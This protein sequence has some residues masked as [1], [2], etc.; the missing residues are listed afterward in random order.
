MKYLK[1]FENNAEVVEDF[2]KN[3]PDNREKAEI[4][5]VVMGVWFPNNEWHTFTVEELEDGKLGGVDDSSAYF[6]EDAYH[7]IVLK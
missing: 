7:V 1:K 6:L 5:D 2:F 3:L 4:G